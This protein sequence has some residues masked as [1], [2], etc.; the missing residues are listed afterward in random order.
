MTV[1]S[2]HETGYVVST[3]LPSNCLT[4][5]FANLTPNVIRFCTI[6]R[7]KWHF[8]SSPFVVLPFFH[9]RSTLIFVV[10]I[11]G[12]SLWAH[13]SQNSRV[14][15]AANLQH[16][17]LQYPHNIV[18]IRKIFSF[19]KP[20][21]PSPQKWFSSVMH[22]EF[23]N[24]AYTIFFGILVYI[25]T[26]LFIKN[27][28]EKSKPFSRKYLCFDLLLLGD[29]IVAYAFIFRYGITCTLLQCFRKTLTRF[30]IRKI[31]NKNRLINKKI[32][33][34]VVIHE[35]VYLWSLRISLCLSLV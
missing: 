18:T 21:L 31:K 30:I 35:C 32:D 16:C 20:P 2:L 1:R 24:A 26:F 14:S 29:R 9:R 23:E 15:I 28:F 6:S 8:A 7:K 12:V 27:H 34:H 11:N 3:I 5:D 17:V 10:W 19:P 33:L 4:V 25:C 13:F 22:V